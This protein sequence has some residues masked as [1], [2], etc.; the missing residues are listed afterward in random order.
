MTKAERIAEYHAIAQLYAA[1]L[2]VEPEVAIAAEDAGFVVD[3]VG[4]RLLQGDG[5]VWSLTP[6]LA[7]R[8]AQRGKYAPVQSKLF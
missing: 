4:A 3:V 7:D 6:E 5:R 1:P 2:G 8:L